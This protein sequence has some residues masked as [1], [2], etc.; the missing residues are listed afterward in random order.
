[1]A[2]EKTFR[3]QRK[4][5]APSEVS[6]EGQEALQAAQNIREA[7]ATEVGEAVDHPGGG[8]QI[9]GN[10][11]PE[12]QAALAKNRNPQAQNADF[13]TTQKESKMSP[14]RRPTPVAPPN[15]TMRV[16][17]SA[18][19]EE[20]INNAKQ[21]HVTWEELKLPSK[22]VFYNGDDGPTDGIIHVRPMTGEEEQILATPRFVKKG[23]AVNM[24]FN[25][26][27]KEGFD[28]SNFLTAD[29]TYLLIF[30]RGISYSP[31]YDVEVKCPFTD[32]QFTTTINLATLF[33]EQ[34]PLNFGPQSLQGTLP[35]TGYNFTY[36]LPT[37]AD[38]QRIQEYR[39]HKA[40]FDVGNNSD[41]T[42]IYR[43]ALLLNDIEGLT[44]KSEIQELLRHLP[45][46][47]VAHLRNCVNEP[48]FGV[49]TKVSIISP[50][51]MEEFELELPLEANFFFPR[52]RKTTQ[53]TTQA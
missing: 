8:F 11:P 4:S 16:T 5:I 33:L 9:Q 35:T 37:G 41:D 7:A 2:D 45:I 24:I 12:F 22:G 51:N 50:F 17:G 28:S 18:R 31:D 23:Q 49:D 13:G 44:D 52:A 34:C 39:D 30:L 48:P 53:N 25:R 6:N 15:T 26:C 47:D 38:E 40:K 19:L 27:I 3:P 20:L 29:R 21:H 10:M 32:K 43:T 1:M 14:T 46:G 42:L 36:R